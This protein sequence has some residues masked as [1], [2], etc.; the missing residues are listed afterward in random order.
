MHLTHRHVLACAALPLLG[1]CFLQGVLPVAPMREVPN[2]ITSPVRQGARLAALWVGHAT[3]LLQM[4]D[5][6]ILTDPVFTSTVG[7][8]SKRL[9]EPG[10]EAKNVP[11]VD[12]VLISHLHFD[13]L[14]LGS[15]EMLER[16]IRRVYLPEGGSVY[17]PD[18]RFPTTELRTWEA[19]AEGGLAVTAVP[20]RHVGWRYG[21]DQTW[22]K[23]S[24]TGYVIQYHGLTV[25]F[26]GDTGF[27]PKNFLAAAQRFPSIDLALLPIAPVNPRAVMEQTHEDP[28]EAV[29]AFLDLGARWMIP[30][31]HDT[32][33]NSFDAPG[34]ALDHLARAM[35]TRG[36]TSE[37]VAVLAIGEQ[38]VFVGKD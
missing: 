10:L 33:I 4:D 18:F 26:A 3:V 17:V 32:F 21:V 31:H 23:K 1:G 8:L 24:F 12:A 5:K 16:K 13:H 19:R 9:V 29:E 38:R 11:S 15:L 34:E 20:V 28:E 7:Q 30:I 22:M 25:Y 6:I 27:E 35:K 14:S 37:Q 2:K 36:L